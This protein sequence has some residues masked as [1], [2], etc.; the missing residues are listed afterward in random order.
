MQSI[1]LQPVPSQIL[2][3]NLGGQNCQ[4]KVYQ[5]DS[6]VYFDLN[7]NG[8]DIVIGVICRNLVPL[9]CIGYLGFIGTFVFVDA[10]G[11]SDPDYNGFNYR[12]YLIYGVPVS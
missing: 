5:K 6:N 1:P 12:Y 2:S 4:I 8:V 9:V 11:T 3:I 10:Q 7:S